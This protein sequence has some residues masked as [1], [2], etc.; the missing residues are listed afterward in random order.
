MMMM[1]MKIIIPVIIKDMADF[2]LIKNQYIKD[3]TKY[4]E[5]LSLLCEYDCEFI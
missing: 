3:I 1:K 5:R 2:H 4:R